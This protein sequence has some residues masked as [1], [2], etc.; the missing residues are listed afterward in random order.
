[1]EEIISKY[2][3]LALA[4]IGDA[5]YNL[6][7]KR[8]AIDRNVKSNDLQQFAAVYCSARTQA[9]ISSY[10]LDNQILDETELMIFKKGRNAKSHNAPKNTD[11]VTYRIST[12]FEALW[13]YWYLSGKQQRMEQ[14]WD[15]IETI[16]V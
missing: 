9:L 14:I 10:L 12:G 13:G 8:K 5:H 2:S 15:I 11:A 4:F 3:P 16:E 6:L 7:V 1:M